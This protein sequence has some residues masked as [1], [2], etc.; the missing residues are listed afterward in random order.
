VGIYENDL[1]VLI[2]SF[3]P[4]MEPLLNELSGYL[5]DTDMAKARQIIT[6]INARIRKFRKANE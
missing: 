3:R 4:D 6:D 1:S 5:N 2:Y